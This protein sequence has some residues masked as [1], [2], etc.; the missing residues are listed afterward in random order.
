MERTLLK[1]ASVKGDICSTEI[2]AESDRD[3]DR[4]AG[5]LLSLMQKDEKLAGE[6]S[7]RGGVKRQKQNT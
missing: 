4:I 1:I 7:E 5:C 6:I 3:Y 2:N